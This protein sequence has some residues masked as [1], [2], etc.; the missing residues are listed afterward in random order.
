[1]ESE[2]WCPG[3]YEVVEGVKKIMQGTSFPEVG[4]ENF[5]LGLG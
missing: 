4:Q 2:C 1:M 5:C 3:W